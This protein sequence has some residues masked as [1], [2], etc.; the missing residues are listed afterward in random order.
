[1]GN[2]IMIIIRRST[3]HVGPLDMFVYLSRKPATLA[4]LNEGIFLSKLL[5]LLKNLCAGKKG[6]FSSLLI[7]KSLNYIMSD[8]QHGFSSLKRQN[9]CTKYVI[10]AARSKCSYIHSTYSE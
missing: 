4:A 8:C 10:F 1:M 6:I 9:E 3:F 7:S 2:E 5:V